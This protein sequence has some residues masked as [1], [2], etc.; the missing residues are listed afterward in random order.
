MVGAMD[1]ANYP[2]HTPFWALA[3]RKRQ[4]AARHFERGEQYLAEAE[5]LEDAA[6]E[7]QRSGAS[8]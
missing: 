3:K 6:A 2:A 7:R 4:C 5:E 8:S 1:V